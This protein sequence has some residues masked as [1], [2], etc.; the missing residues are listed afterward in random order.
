MCP[1]TSFRNGGLSG[2]L[3]SAGSTGS[4]NVCNYEYI[5]N[6]GLFRHSSAE[7][8]CH[9]L[10]C[11]AVPLVNA[12]LGWIMGERAQVGVEVVS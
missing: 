4:G 8:L 5:Y 3:S 6:F 2:L 10:G 1:C 12:P 11:N 7:V 9:E